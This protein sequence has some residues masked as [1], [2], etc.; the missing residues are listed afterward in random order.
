VLVRGASAE[1]GGLNPNFF[2]LTGLVEPRAVLLLA[3]SGVRFGTGAA[4][5]GPLYVRGR[6][7]SELLFLP[8]PDPLARRWGDEAEATFGGVDASRHGVGAVLALE[9]LEPVLSRALHAERTLCYVRSRD[10]VLDGSDDADARF[11]GRVR[12]RFFDVRL[13]DATPIVHGLRQRKDAGEVARVRAALEVTAEAFECV[14]ARVRPGLR[15]CEIEAEITRVYRTRGARHAFEPI[16]ASGRNALALHY[17]KN[18]GHLGEGELLLIDTGADLE[19]YKCDVTRTIPVAGSFSERQRQVYAAV[20]R[21][22]EAAIERCRPGSTLSDVHEAAWNSL[23]ST[24]LSAFFV[25]GTS[26]HLGLE[27]HDAGD[28]H[29]PL[30]AGAVVTVEPGAYIDD[31][32]IGV[33]IE[34]D[35]LVTDGR[36]QVLSEAIPRSIEAIEARLH[37]RAS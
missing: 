25:H 4:H 13:V 7:A 30:E 22:Q 28:V 12:E 24:G 23:E 18:S 9:E 35:V 32:A 11:V 3:A 36:P 21:A 31:E 27:T 29:R 6:T 37:E 26:H 2:Y 34:D 33:R 15:E 19:R 14:L 16:V 20:L 17:R 5:P 1:P 8:R 10:A